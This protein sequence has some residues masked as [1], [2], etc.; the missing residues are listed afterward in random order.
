MKSKEAIND[1][2]R[3]DFGQLIASLEQA[4]NEAE[5]VLSTARI[6][7]RTGT[8]YLHLL[9]AVERLHMRALALDAKLG[10]TP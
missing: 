8:Q 6:H 5:A 2:I 1:D 4:V 3:S 7:G 10:E 9:H